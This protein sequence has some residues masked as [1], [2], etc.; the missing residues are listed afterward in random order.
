MFEGVKIVMPRGEGVLPLRVA[1]CLGA[2]AARFVLLSNE[3]DNVARMSKHC[4]NFIYSDPQ[5]DP[6]LLAQ[7]L[8]IEECSSPEI[9]LPITTDGFLFASR[10][11]E[12]LLKRFRLPPVST[13]DSL[14][15]A[16]DKWRLYE[17]AIRNEIPVLRS[18]LMSD[19]QASA[20]ENFVFPA[21]VKS[22]QKESGQGARK[23]GSAA[24]L[25]ALR[26]TLG[27]TEAED[28]FVQ[29]FVEGE[30]ISLSVFCEH[31]EIRSY[32]LWRAVCY[33]KVEYQV[34]LC[35]TFGENDR[36]LRVGRRLLKALEWEGICDID[37]FMDK[38]S[39]E[40]LLLEVNTRF[41][42]NV[43]GCASHGVNFPSLM[44]ERA[45]AADDTVWPTQ[46]HG[47]YCH[48]KGLLTALRAPKIRSAVLRDPLKVLGIAEVLRDPGP[49]V[50]KLFLKVKGVLTSWVRRTRE[51][52]NGFT[53]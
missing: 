39:G 18:T 9:V 14:M 13:I 50:Y 10:N 37:F 4:S 51:S 49:E 27:K 28:Y 12:A 30:D 42:R 43:E 22:R 52:R 3:R 17:F 11:R 45:L 16:S 36:V 26:E 15:I 35:V 21:L 29:R 20:V 46:S 48:P 7:L 53:G 31:G 19:I 34:P 40:V 1:R 33:G 38:Q 6:E 41:W 44:C 32:T 23:V 24:E 2:V 8:G 5:T 47:A 25:R